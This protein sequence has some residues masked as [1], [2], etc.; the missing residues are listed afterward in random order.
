MEWS[1]IYVYLIWHIWPIVKGTSECHGLVHHVYS[2]GHTIQLF[3][4]QGAQAEGHVAEDLA[5][6]SIKTGG[7]GSLGSGIWWDRRVMIWFHFMY[8]SV[9]IYLIFL[10]W[11][12]F[13]H[14]LYLLRMNTSYQP[15]SFH[16][17][18]LIINLC[19][20]QKRIVSAS[21][22]HRLKRRS[23]N[24]QIINVANAHKYQH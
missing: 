18:V 3:L 8:S 19:I 16:N 13:I 1:N 10:F 11:F 5:E 12:Y 22:W 2:T 6:H 21:A 14:V 15:Y 24:L 17:I 20:L 9:N 23:Y 7:R 4:M